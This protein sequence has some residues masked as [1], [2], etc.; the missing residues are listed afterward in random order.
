LITPFLGGGIQA[1]SVDADIVTV[2]DNQ[3]LGGSFVPG[4]TAGNSQSGGGGIA[5]TGSVS[6]VNSTIAE[7]ETTLVDTPGQQI[8]TSFGSGILATSLSLDHV[9]IA[10]NT[11][12]PA[13]QV[14]QLTTYRSVILGS[15]GQPACA[16][17]RQGDGPSSFALVAS[18]YN[19][20]NDSSCALA[21]TGD[22]Q[23]DANFAL[24]PL[25]DNGG[26]VPTRAP[27]LSSVLVDQIPVNAC[28]IAIDARGVTRPQGNACDIGAVEVSF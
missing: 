7:N 28:P 16:A 11:G 24:G 17:G 12:A 15:S 26:S 3:A 8:H 14:Q 25:A 10:D 1:G 23:S 27:A 22:H 18:A 13:V 4:W 20:A 6:L 21:G 19:W 2:A 5:A 9:T